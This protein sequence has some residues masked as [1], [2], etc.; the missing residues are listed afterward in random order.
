MRVRIPGF[1][2]EVSK[3]IELPDIGE[4]LMYPAFQLI[5]A[6]DFRKC[7][8]EFQRFLFDR[9]PLKNNKKFVYVRSGVWLLEPGTR[10]HVRRDGDW[11]F[12]C[13]SPY[14]HRN[15]DQQFYILSSPCL[16]LTEFNLAP[17]EIE[18]PPDETYG[19]LQRRICRSPQDF[20][21]VGRAIEPCRVYTVEN[22]L[23]RA[24]EPS[25]IEFRFFLRVV[26]SDVPREW[27]TTPLR[28]VPLRSSDTGEAHS[29]ILYDREGVKLL[30]PSALKPMTSSEM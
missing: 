24:V 23:H 22:H 6:E 17:V 15:P 26:E 5:L 10:S 27:R 29:H 12:D 9:V 14:G 30:Y 19:D 11:H 2:T 28:S 21:V 4:L 7:A 20:G 8:T 25:R 16:A 18:S 1:P 13:D 3:P